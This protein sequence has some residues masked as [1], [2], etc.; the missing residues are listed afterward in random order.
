MNISQSGI[1]LIKSFEGLRLK[2]YKP[3]SNEEFYTIGYGH[4]GADVRY[5]AEIDEKEAEEILKIDIRKFVDGVER[6]IIVKVNQNQFDALVSFAYN[7]GLGAFRTSTLLEYVNKGQ[8]NEAAEQFPLWI[9]SGGKVLNGLIKRRQKEKALFLKPVA[10]TKTYKI[11]SGDTLSEI[12]EEFKTSVSAIKKLNSSI[13]N[14]DEI[15]TGQSI[16]IPKK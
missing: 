8:F 14:V 12:A 11:K 13:K 6:Y 15:K 16:K 9:H 4:Y 2:A 1:N 7:V 3:V 10:A 5:N